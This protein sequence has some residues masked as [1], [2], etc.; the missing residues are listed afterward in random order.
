MRPLAADMV[1]QLPLGNPVRTHAGAIGLE[2][3]V[4]LVEFSFEHLLIQE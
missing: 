1:E 4:Y 2:L 3:P